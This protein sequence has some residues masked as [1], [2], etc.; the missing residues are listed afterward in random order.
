MRSVWPFTDRVVISA[1]LG[2]GRVTVCFFNVPIRVSLLLRIQFLP[3][4]WYAR[5]QDKDK[6]PIFNLNLLICSR[7]GVKL[8]TQRNLTTRRHF[9]QFRTTFDLPGC[10]N[11]VGETAVIIARMNTQH[12][13]P[14]WHTIDQAATALS[15][16]TR[17]I[18][19]M[20]QAGKLQYQDIGLGRQ[21]ILR[22]LFPS[23]EQAL[24]TTAP[25]KR[26]RNVPQ[27]LTT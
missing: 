4:S 23:A 6:I 7:V 3:R 9:G 14:A 20:I 5:V 16:S 1:P 8:K 18:K 13:Q 26:R 15:C 17:H 22:V 24:R 2:I 27:I 21:K 11:R 12:L 19:R 10:T 25:K